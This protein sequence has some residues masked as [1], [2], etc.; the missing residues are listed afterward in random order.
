MYKVALPDAFMLPTNGVTLKAVYNMLSN[1]FKSK[2]GCLFSAQLEYSV[3]A[4]SLA[5]LCVFFYFLLSANVGI[6]IAWCPGDADEASGNGKTPIV[7]FHRLLG[8]DFLRD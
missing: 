7:H 3:S 6:F 8:I 2:R 4:Q 5:C 1:N